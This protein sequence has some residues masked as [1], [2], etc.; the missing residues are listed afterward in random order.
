MATDLS[1]DEIRED[2]EADKSWALRQIELLRTAVDEDDG[3]SM[4][5]FQCRV[6]DGAVRDYVDALEAYG[7]LRHSEANGG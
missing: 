4:V 5:R 2:V 6:T 7:R 1:L 3:S